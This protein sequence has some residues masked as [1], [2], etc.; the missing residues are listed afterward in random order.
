MNTVPELQSDTSSSA[1]ASSSRPP[2]TGRKTALVAAGLTLGFA[3]LALLR[4]PP[5]VW[6]VVWAED[7]RIFLEQRLDLGAIGSI[8]YPYAGYLQFMPRIITDIAVAVAPL[9]Y[10]AQLVTVLVCLVSGGIAALV[11][12]LSR[13]L[14]S[15]VVLRLV[16]AS[17][18]VLLGSLRIEIL[19]NMAN[20]H[21]L[22]L[23]LTPWVLLFRPARWRTSW[24]LGVLLLVAALT[25]IQ[26]A[27]FLPLAFLGL[28]NRK[29]WP[30]AGGLLLGL[31]GQGIATFFFPRPGYSDVT[32]T[33]LDMAKGYVAEVLV[34]LASPSGL[35]YVVN[36]FGW[37]V[38]A[39]LALP[40]LAAIVIGARLSRRRE[41]LFLG[42]LVWGATIPWIAAA[43][44]NASEVMQFDHYSDALLTHLP[45]LRYGAV[46]GM[47]L[48]TIVVVAVDRLWRRGSRPLLVIGGVVVVAGL[49]LQL[50]WF[51]RP[52]TFR[53][54]GPTFSVE[55]EQAVGECGA[56]QNDAK[57]DG[58]PT[59]FPIRLT[60]EVVREAAD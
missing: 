24:L 23:W 11:F 10:F 18:T 20:I 57:L 51:A 27:Y 36:T 55:L 60:C 14:V 39:L 42:T 48:I 17:V 29:T 34:S 13:D 32:V 54:T 15:S 4:L 44:I 26:V 52:I 6:G 43:K 30:V 56:G 2:A 53:D 7:G 9:E 25:E 46:P 47:F 41:L 22:F 3:I 58:A 50:L 8:F 19:G 38:S 49:A 33:I 1:S 28:R 16:I 35:G 21:W 37:A 5:H 31:L 59:F 40:F 45:V 12:F